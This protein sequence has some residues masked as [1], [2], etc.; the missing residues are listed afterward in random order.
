MKGLAHLAGA[1]NVWSAHVTILRYPASPSTSPIPLGYSS[2]PRS[3][4]VLSPQPTIPNIRQ[5]A[6]SPQ[7]PLQAF[8]CFQSP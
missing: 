6:R 1:R 2:E 3:P 8:G 5:Y 4:P 7:P